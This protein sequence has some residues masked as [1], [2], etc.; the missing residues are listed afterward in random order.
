MSVWWRR[1]DEADDGPGAKVIQMPGTEVALHQQAD[2]VVAEEES[3]APLVPARLLSWLEEQRTRPLVPS[4]ARMAGQARW[5]LRASPYFMRRGLRNCLVEVAY[6]VRGSGWLV[7][8]WWS[9]VRDT[10]WQEDKEAAKK[11]SD[12]KY[13]TLLDQHRERVKFR[14]I[15][16]LSS[17]VPSTGG[18]WIAVEIWPMW[19]A[20]AGVGVAGVLDLVGRHTRKRDPD[21]PEISELPVVGLL[22]SAP[23]KLIAEWVRQALVGEGLTEVNVA[24]ASVLDTDRMEH[25][26]EIVS[27]QAIKPEDMRAIELFCDFPKGAVRH[28]AV[29]GSSQRSIIAIRYG[30]PLANAPYAPWVPT[31]SRSCLDPQDLGISVGDKPFAPV[32]AG[33]H[34]VVL[35]TTR[36]GKTEGSLRRIFDRLTSCRDAELWG[37]DLSEGPE[38]ELWTP[39]LRKV[40][41]TTKELAGLFADAAEEK[42]RRAEILRSIA[43]GERP[44]L[45]MTTKWTPELGPYIFIIF[46]EFHNIAR[47]NGKGNYKDEPNFLMMTE[48]GIRTYNKYGMH[49]ILA[50][51]NAGCGDWGSTQLFRNIGLKIIGPCDKQDSTMVFGAERRDAGWAPHELQPAQGDSPNDAGKVYVDGLGFTDPDV[52]RTYRPETPEKVQELVARRIA[53]GFAAAYRATAIDAH[54]VP[55]ALAALDLALTAYGADRLPSETCVNYANQ[56]GG[57]WTQTSIADALRPLGV[58]TRK[59]RSEHADG[60]SVM[61]YHRVDVDNALRKL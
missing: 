45:K 60:K 13:L 10:A 33:T 15:A 1:R 47:F 12:A 5:Y 48:D 7:R 54:E 11:V 19:A 21:A 8:R 50:S 37:A 29:S 32:L 34:T 28:R 41:F 49:F 14:V 36:G 39:V 57:K 35:S 40:A 26:V 24:Q 27:Q 30:D 18:V 9:W 58:E 3:D 25:R 17:T 16:T 56:H 42:H 59:A 38:L 55:P 22:E 53:D 6:P 4:P 20:V 51:Q 31:G 2:V 52:Y 23:P 44:D 61:C 46:D 43:R